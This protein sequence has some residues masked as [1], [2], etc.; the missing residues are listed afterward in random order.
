MVI[1]CQAKEYKRNTQRKVKEEV[2]KEACEPKLQEDDPLSVLT[3]II[4][5]V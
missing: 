3:A 1:L 2:K 4:A 5:Q